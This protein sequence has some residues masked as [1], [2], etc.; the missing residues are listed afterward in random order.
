MMRAPSISCSHPDKIFF[1]SGITKGELFAYYESSAPLVLPYIKDRPESMHRQPDGANDEGFFQKNATSAPWWIPRH[2]TVSDDGKTISWLVCSNRSAL[3]YL[4]NA[5]CIELNPWL[6]RISDPDRPDFCLIDIDAKTSPFVDVITVARTVHDV[7]HDWN[8]TGIPKTSGKTG[9]HVAIP[10]GH[11]YT[12]DES[13]LAC[14]LIV[15]EVHRR[16]PAITSVERS[17][18]KRS[19]KIYLDALQNRRMQT[20]AAPYS[21]RPVPGACVS[22]PLDW[23]EVA[24]GLDPRRWTIRTIADRV[25]SVGDLWKPV[26]GPGASLSALV[27]DLRGTAVRPARAPAPGPSPR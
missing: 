23:T 26:L 17:P 9:L 10:L 6:S 19:R 21:A 7:V 24:S 22:T 20:M 25:A 12:Y 14:T 8:L 15:E 16:L 13:R 1:D 27:R 18:A 5:G 4:V 11:R 3:L 2:T